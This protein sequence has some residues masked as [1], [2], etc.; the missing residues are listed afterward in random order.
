MDLVL[1]L[2][3]CEKQ[4]REVY[5]YTGAVCYD[6]LDYDLIRALDL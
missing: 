2:K 4:V 1:A 3:V 6:S 5:A